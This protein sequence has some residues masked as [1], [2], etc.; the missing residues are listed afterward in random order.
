MSLNRMLTFDVSRVLLSDV[1]RLLLWRVPPKL[2]AALAGSW[3]A[4]SGQDLGLWPRSVTVFVALVSAGPFVF[5][6]S[7]RRAERRGA[8]RTGK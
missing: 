4:A 1:N 7:R 5:S 6:L 3:L 8:T 2:L